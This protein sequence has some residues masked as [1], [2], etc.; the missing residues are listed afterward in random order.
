MVAART[1]TV[2]DA[3]KVVR[4]S[5]DPFDSDSDDKSKDEAASVI[6][7]SIM[8][9]IFGQVYDAMTMGAASGVMGSQLNSARSQ[10]SINSIDRTD[11]YMVRAG[12]SKKRARRD[13]NMF[14]IND[15]LGSA[16]KETI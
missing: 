5:K 15:S 10:I 11:L 4:D 1:Q 14:A 6:E 9:N 8:K 7:S 12:S 13:I 3:T 2:N 16:F